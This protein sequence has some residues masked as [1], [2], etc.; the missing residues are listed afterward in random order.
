MVHEYILDERDCIILAI[1][2]DGYFTML[3]FSHN[4][5]PGLKDNS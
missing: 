3:L 5:L 1:P 2:M 4:I